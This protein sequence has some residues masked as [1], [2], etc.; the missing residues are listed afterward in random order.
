VSDCLFCKIAAKEI[1]SKIVRET[2]DWVAFRDIQPQAPTHIL[3]VPRQHLATVNELDP[4][5]AA[6]LIEGAQSVA[7]EEGLS[8]YRLVFNC[9][10]EAGQSVW[11]VHLHLLGGRTMHWPPG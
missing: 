3:L 9:G 7:K 1:P 6:T 5:T 2:P 8:S 4:A 11:H 10:S